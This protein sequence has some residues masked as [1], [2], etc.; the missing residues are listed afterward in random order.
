MQAEFD[1]AYYECHALRDGTCIEQEIT[2]VLEAVPTQNETCQI[3]MLSDDLHAL[4]TYD[5]GSKWG[6]QT[7]TIEP[8]KKRVSFRGSGTRLQPL[9][10]MPG[11]SPDRAAAQPWD[12]SRG[13]IATIEIAITPRVGRRG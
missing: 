11:H 12:G 10:V 6:N 4:P 3:R 1:G 7:H 5:D 2:R 8:R 9:I 13:G